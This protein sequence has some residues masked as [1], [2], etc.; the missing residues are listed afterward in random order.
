M[1]FLDPLIQPYGGAALLSN[2]TAWTRLYFATPDIGTYAMSPMLSYL[3]GRFLA[4]WKL[5]PS[6]EDEPGQR[7][8]HAQST[9]GVSWTPGGELFPRMNSTE[10]P[11]VALFAAPTLW[12][13]GRVYAAATPTQICLYPDQYQDVLLLRR[14]HDD[15]TLGPI[16]WAADAVPPG[17]AVASA[18][19][20]VTTASQQDAETRADVATLTPAPAGVPCPPP[21]AANG[22]KCEAC[23]GGCQPWAAVANVSSLENERS[24]F[25]VGA[26]VDVLLY[27]SRS[28]ALYASVRA[29]ADGNASWSAAARTNITDDVANFN[30][31]NLPDGRAYLVSNAMLN[32]FRDPLF[33]SVTD[34]G[35]LAFVTTAVIGSCEQAVF[36]NPPAQ[37]WG[38]V[39]RHNGGAKEGGLQY[40]Q[41]AVVTAPAAVA[42]L[43]VILSQNKE[44]IWVGRTP[45]ADLPPG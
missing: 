30:A 24:H 18:A 14:V 7:V 5:S 35:G 3:N 43:Y 28:N 45:F 23:R 22:T 15:G 39:F 9:D 42:G 4:S 31:G 13:R 26:G 2:R 36:A 25:T 16:F 6:G 10:S 29:W 40:P 44:D 21:A 11:R 38:C 41:A 12:L 1:P 20:N 8:M 27:R 33:L 19:A 32:V 34:A 17:F 37:P